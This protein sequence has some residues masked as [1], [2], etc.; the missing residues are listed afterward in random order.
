VPGA[1][2]HVMVF[3]ED[4]EA[5]LRFLT[6]VAHL[7]PV[8]RF[9]NGDPPEVAAFGWSIQCSTRGAFV[10]EGPGTGELVEIPAEL[11]GT[12]TPGIRFLGVPNRD[13]VGAGQAAAA[14]GFKTRGP[15][16]IKTPMGTTVT[17]FEANAGG[18][19]FELIR[20]G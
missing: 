3:T 9:E 11:R 14:A 7:S 16:Y 12:V 10:G 19:P 20:F 18:L 17:A 15:L 1:L 4:L 6:E 2:S 5:T 8:R 13:P